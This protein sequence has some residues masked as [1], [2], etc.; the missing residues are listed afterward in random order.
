[1]SSRSWQG[2][3]VSE[4]KTVEVQYYAILREQS[5]LSFESVNTQATTAYDLYQELA[6]RHHFSLPL[7]LVRVAVNDQFEPLTHQLK[8]ADVVVFIPPVAGG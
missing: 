8:N 3:G 6:E 4:C 2:F 7:E 5:G 1:M